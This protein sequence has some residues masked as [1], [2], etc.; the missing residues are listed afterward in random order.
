MAL[1]LWT[2]PDSLLLSSGASLC[3]INESYDLGY[4]LLFRDVLNGKFQQSDDLHRS[5]EIIQRFISIS[6]FLRT[7]YNTM[8]QFIRHRLLFNH[9]V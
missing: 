1:L 7:C 8:M 6:L 5:S 9:H 3:A 4:V 2:I